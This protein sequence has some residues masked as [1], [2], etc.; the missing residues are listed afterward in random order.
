[1][2]RQDDFLKSQLVLFGWR[3]GREY[4]GHTASCMIMS[5]LANR[6]K[7]GWG[8]WLDIL[9]NIPKYSAVKE[10][11]TGSPQMWDPTFVHLLHDVETIFSGSRDDAQGAVYW[12]DMTHVETAFFK[13]KILQNPNRLIVGNMN[14][15]TFFKLKV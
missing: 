15:L 8:A 10:Q 4:G 9:D 13:E 7:A 5:A 6:H 14:S 11:P 1:M 12:A 3:A 2:L